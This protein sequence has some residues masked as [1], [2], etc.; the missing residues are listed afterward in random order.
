MH[1]SIVRTGRL[2]VSRIQGRGP[3]SERAAAAG[4]HLWRT[5]GDITDTY[6][7]IVPIGFGQSGLEPF[8]GPD[9]ENDPSMLE[10]G[11]GGMNENEYHMHMTPGC[12]LAAQ[13]LAGND[14]NESGYVRPKRL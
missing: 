14:P 4:V 8:T 13:P 5:S 9:H 1:D 10:V 2:M 7:H 6:A 11:N 3:A 12:L